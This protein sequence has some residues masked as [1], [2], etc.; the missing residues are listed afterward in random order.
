MRRWRCALLVAALSVF[1]AGGAA[2]QPPDP[3]IQ[4]AFIEGAQRLQA[5]DYEGAARIF[6]ALLEKTASPRIKLEL[7][8]A[9][10]HLGEYRESRRLFKEV[11]LEPELPWRVRDNIDVFLRRMDD[12]EGYVRFSASIVSDSNPRNITSE[13]EFT[14]GGVRLTFEPP[15][16]NQRVTGVRYAI[17]AHQPFWRERRLSGYFTGSYLDYPASHLDRLTLDTGLSKGLMTLAGAVRAGIEAGWFGGSSLYEFPYVELG[18]R[19]SE[20]PTHRLDGAVKGGRVNFP[21]FDHLDANY[22]SATLFFARGL[23]QALAASLAGVVEVS[24]ARERPY[25]YYGVTLEPG[26]SWLFG[27]AGVLVKANL[28]LGHRQYAAEDPLFG[29]RRRDQRT[30]LELSVREKLWRC[31]NFTPALVFSFERTRSNI[32]FYS[33]RKANA[34]VVLE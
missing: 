15:E 21:H 25:S 16:D 8:R 34:S 32:E 12:I 9:L 30:A 11:A 26:A 4:R 10:F 1:L 18:Q 22:G 23:S 29:T 17:Q 24:D 2:A 7:A 14:I 20:S 13:R 33:Y 6:R 31:M 19:L 28:P 5:G 27:E 3:E